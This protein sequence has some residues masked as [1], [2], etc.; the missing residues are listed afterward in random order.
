MAGTLAFAEANVR[1]ECIRAGFVMMRDRGGWKRRW[2]CIGTRFVA[3]FV[4]DISV[5][6]DGP[7][8]AVELDAVTGL[9]D[10]VEL[11]GGRL[12]R[13]VFAVSTSCR[14]GTLT[15]QAS[16]ERSKQRWIKSFDGMLAR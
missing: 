3:W 9:V 15:M 10:D 7:L 14:A 2:L 12:R 11:R 6:V 4:D 16:D 5:C 13:F 1:Q 8:G